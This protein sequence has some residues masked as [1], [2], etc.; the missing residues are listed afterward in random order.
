MEL[1]SVDTPKKPRKKKTVKQMPFVMASAN[2]PMATIE[3]GYAPRRCDVEGMGKEQRDNLMMCT[4][5]LIAKSAKL[6][7]GTLVR[8]PSH[9]I[10]WILENINGE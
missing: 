1:P 2:I 5:G 8:R 3:H 9:A 7:N 6:K 10:K 4:N